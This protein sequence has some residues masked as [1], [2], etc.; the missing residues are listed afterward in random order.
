M[1]LRVLALPPRTLGEASETPFLLVFDRCA[2]AG[3]ADPFFTRLKETVGAEA[4][5]V[6]AEEVELDPEQ[7][8][9]VSA[10]GLDLAAL[11][12]MIEG[13]VKVHS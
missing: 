5:L 3:I 13:H 7:V 8:A 2:D 1:R 12:S 11:E 9:A 10:D 6:L 4:V